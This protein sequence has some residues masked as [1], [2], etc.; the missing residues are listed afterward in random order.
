MIL[1][2]VFE[3]GAGKLNKL[4]GEKAQFKFEGGDSETETITFKSAALGEGASGKHVVK[5]SAVGAN[6]EK[7]TSILCVLN[8]Q[9][10]SG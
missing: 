1:K 3:I 6:S 5:V 4:S 2:V 7:V 8:D 9:V 10:M